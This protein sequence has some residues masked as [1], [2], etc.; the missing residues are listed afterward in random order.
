MK[1]HDISIS[2]YLRKE[3][4][5]TTIKRSKNGLPTFGDQ[6]YPIS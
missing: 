4:P 5:E 6:M 1:K 3:T 2:E